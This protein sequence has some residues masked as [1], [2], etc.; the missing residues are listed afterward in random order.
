MKLLP[1]QEER[2]L[3]SLLCLF[4]ALGWFVLG[5]LIT[6][7]PGAEQWWFMTTAALFLLVFLVSRGSG[8]RIAA[9]VFIFVSLLF[10]FQGYLRGVRYQAWLAEHP[11]PRQAA[12][13]P[14]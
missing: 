7:Y 13:P 1:T 4:L 3:F 14:P 2:H 11:L 12:T 8:Y 5:F 9:V 6:F 10:A